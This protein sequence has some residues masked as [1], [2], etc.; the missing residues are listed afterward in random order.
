[1]TAL[2]RDQTQIGVF[3][4]LPGG[5]GGKTRL[6]ADVGPARAAEL[7]RAFLEDVLARALLVAPHGT[8]WW[9]AAEPARATGDLLAAAAER[10]PAGVRL[11]AQEGPHLGA[12]M[13]HALDRM[14]ATGPALLLGADAPDVPLPALVH[15]IALLGDDEAMA[16]AP[17]MPRHRLVL[18]PATDGGFWLVGVD[19]SPGG[20]LAARAEWG[21]P[22]VHARTLADAV[23]ATARWDVRTIESWSDVDTGKDLEALCARLQAARARGD[24]ARP[25]WPARTAALVLAGP[26]RDA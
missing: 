14:L 3:G 1:M 6:A 21:G 2:A 23:A 15:A 12:A 22:S 16:A 17:A 25:G 4:R 9:V 20:L 5:P 13:E 10:A 8:W 19:A 11:A 7:S 26:A 18:G 24:A